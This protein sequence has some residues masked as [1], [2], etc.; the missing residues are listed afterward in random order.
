MQDNLKEKYMKEL[1]KCKLN[2]CE[3]SKSIKWFGNQ[4]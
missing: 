1:H 2:N 4:I 3:W